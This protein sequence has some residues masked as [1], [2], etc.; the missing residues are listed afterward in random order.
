MAGF[1]DEYGTHQD[2]RERITKVLVISLL[3]LLAA[4]VLG[5]ILFFFLHNYREEGRVRHFFDSLAAHDYKAAYATFGCTDAK[6]CPD[7]PFNKFMEDWGPNSG[8]SDTSNFRIARS[9]S[10]GSGV[11]LTVDF[12]KNQEERLWVE[13]KD[14]TVGFPPFDTCPE[15]PR[16]FWHWPLWPFWA[17]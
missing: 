9:R 6:P 11:I 12:G 7:Y 8:R 10:C 13:R 17:L 4:D 14:K 1:L 16:P 5:G 15:P 3:A 2:K